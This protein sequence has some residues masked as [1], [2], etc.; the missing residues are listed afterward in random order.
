MPSQIEIKIEDEMSFCHASASYT[1]DLGEVGICPMD[2]GKVDFLLKYGADVLFHELTHVALWNQTTEK[3]IL[4]S[5]YEDFPTIF[6]Y[7]VSGRPTFKT[8]E[9]TIYD[10]GVAFVS[11]ALVNY[12]PLLALATSLIDLQRM[13]FTKLP[14]VQEKKKLYHSHA[15]VLIDSFFLIGPKTT[16]QD[17]LHEVLSKT[18]Q[19]YSGNLEPF[20]RTVLARGMDLAQAS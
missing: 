6:S 1:N 5:D 20:N 10:P 18:K 15:R 4:S 14:S 8:T 19:V 3:F 16:E 7:L 9:D 12:G 11:I 2:E 17:V 13:I